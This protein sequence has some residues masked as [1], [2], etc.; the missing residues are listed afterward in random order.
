MEDLYATVVTRLL[1][2][3]TKEDVIVGNLV[4]HLKQKGRVKLLPGIL[5]AL[6][7]QMERSKTLGASVEVAT[8]EGEKAALAEA[9]LL[10]IDA[11][12]AVVNP[13]LLSGW[14]ARKEG[15][16]VDRSGKRALTDI[17]RGIVKA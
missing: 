9:R 7:I 15:V 16:L 8:K 4:K 2:G 14:R 17:Y 3:G 6:K 13:I 11:E 1:A 5:R 12:E 10:G